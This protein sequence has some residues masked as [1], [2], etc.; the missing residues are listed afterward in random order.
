MLPALYEWLYQSYR[1]RTADFKANIRAFLKR[2]VVGQEVDNVDYMKS[3]K[4]DVFEFRV[5]IQPRRERT[6]I[7]GA[8]IRPDIFVAIHWKFR[9][10][11]G[12]EDDPKW[13]AAIQRVV[14]EFQRLFPGQPMVRSAPFS[15]CVTS[16]A[17]DVMA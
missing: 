11:F 16:N 14:D 3:W 5:Q 1:K 4:D 13:D 9:L 10:D 12:G 7:F 6:R 15:N 2:F 17:Y 8:F